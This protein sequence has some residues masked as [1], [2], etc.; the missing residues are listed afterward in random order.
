[1]LSVGG[2]SISDSVTREK[3]KGKG[4]EENQRESLKH[5]NSPD[6]AFLPQTGNKDSVYFKRLREDFGVQVIPYEPSSG[7]PE[8]L[9]FIS[10]LA[11]Q[12]HA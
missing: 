1:M 9:E 3:N 8:V 6:Y 7:H 10:Y 5:E 2:Y 12:V 4:G 11:D